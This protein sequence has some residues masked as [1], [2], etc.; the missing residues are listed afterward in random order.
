GRVLGRNT[1]PVHPQLCRELLRTVANV[2][3]QIL[4]LEDDRSASEGE[5]FALEPL[6][7]ADRQ[8]GDGC[9]VRERARA[10]LERPASD[11]LRVEDARRACIAEPA[12]LES[13][14]Q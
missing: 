6:G 3:A 4:R 10:A 5:D 2:E 8:V 12:R 9:A 14:A 11:I 1:D 7:T 13:F